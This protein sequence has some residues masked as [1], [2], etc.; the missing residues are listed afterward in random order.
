[1]STLIKFKLTAVELSRLE[2]RPNNARVESSNL[3][4]ANLLLQNRS[5]IRCRN[6]T[7]GEGLCKTAKK[8][9]ET[10]IELT[11][12]AIELPRLDNREY[13]EGQNFQKP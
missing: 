2:H 1:M 9:M 11:K 7:Q 8:T 3:S 5:F 6:E 4:M 10:Q 13:H 12:T